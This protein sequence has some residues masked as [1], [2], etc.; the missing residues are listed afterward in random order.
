MRDFDPTNPEVIDETEL[1][2]IL[3]QAIDNLDEYVDLIKIISQK[4]TISLESIALR[5]DDSSRL[6]GGTS[7][8]DEIARLDIKGDYEKRR[9]SLARIAL[10][11]LDEKPIVATQV[12][13]GLEYYLDSPYGESG[14]I[15]PQKVGSYLKGFAS[16]NGEIAWPKLEEIKDTKGAALDSNT[17]YD[18]TEELDD[19]KLSVRLHELVTGSGTVISVTFRLVRVNFDSMLAGTSFHVMTSEQQSALAI[20]HVEP[21]GGVDIVLASRETTKTE[22]I[23]LSDLQNDEV[24]H[25]AH[26]QVT[27]TQLADML[28]VLDYLDGLVKHTDLPK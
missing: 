2:E 5:V 9:F 21:N 3:Q 8:E 20:D 23:D 7:V 26:N 6:P 15:S 11:S 12:G 4:R 18:F 10:R 28:E 24:I 27:R 19:A 16:K 25:L 14:F 17:T 22:R 13:S 1:L